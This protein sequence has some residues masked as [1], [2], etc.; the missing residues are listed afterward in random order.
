MRPQREI[1]ELIE[2][3]EWLRGFSTKFLSTSK[4]SVSRAHA[5]LESRPGCS[6]SLSGVLVDTW[7]DS[8][9]VVDTRSPG[10]GCNKQCEPIREAT[11]QFYEEVEQ[12][13]KVKL[14]LEQLNDIYDTLKYEDALRV[15]FAAFRL[16]FMAKDL[17]A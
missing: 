11:P 17:V 4:D 10:F 13:F 5:E 12:E 2:E 16:R 3:W 7:Y 9:R 6:N 8:F 14:S 1:L 15:T